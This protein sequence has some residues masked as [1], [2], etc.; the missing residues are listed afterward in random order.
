MTKYRCVVIIGFQKIAKEEILLTR[1]NITVT[2]TII[3]TVAWWH[4]VVRKPRFQQSATTCSG[5][6]EKKTLNINVVGKNNVCS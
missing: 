4:G 1:Y 5:T 6:G 2:T 3:T